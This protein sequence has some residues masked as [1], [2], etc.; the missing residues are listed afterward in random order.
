[1]SNPTTL[2]FTNEAQAVDPTTVTDK[3]LLVEKVVTIDGEEVW[4]KATS[5][6]SQA[7]HIPKVTFCCQDII[8]GKQGPWH[9]A[10][11]FL[12]KT[13]EVYYDPFSV[14]SK[15]EGK[16]REFKLKVSIRRNDGLDVAY[17]H[18]LDD[19]WWEIMNELLKEDPYVEVAVAYD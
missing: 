11:I 5:T 19:E 9:Y 8:P 2:N 3:T 10:K 4:V 12:P 15:G 13:Y 18:I 6:H 14:L 16:F 7:R 17:A 1:M